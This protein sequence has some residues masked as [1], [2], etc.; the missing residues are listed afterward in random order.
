MINKTN[1]SIDKFHNADIPLKDF[2]SEGIDRRRHLRFLCKQIKRNRY[3]GSILEFGVHQGRTIRIIAEQFPDETIWGFDSFEGLPEDW[4]TNNLEKSSHPAGHFSLKELPEVPKNVKLI[5][6]FFK[7]S[8][9]T[10]LEKNNIDRIKLLHIDCDL[11]S[12]TIDVLFK[13]N[14]FIKTNTIIV[15]DEFYP[16]GDEKKYTLWEEGEY[17]ALYEWTC[18]FDRSFKIISRSR[19]Q[20]CAI[21]IVK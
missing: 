6:G 20:Q 8:I 17:K 10:W 18:H 14:N 7:D 12:S 19:H 21:Q 4:F 5:K 15:F 2:K 3:E 13:F 1:F 16:W 9:P 11:Y